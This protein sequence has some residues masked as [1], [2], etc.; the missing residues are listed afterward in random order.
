MD[1]HPGVAPP[2]IMRRFIEWNRYASW[3]LDELLDP[4]GRRGA[5]SSDFQAA[6]ESCL[7]PGL[8]IL[9]VGGGKTPAVTPELKVSLGAQVI[10]IDISQEELSAAPAGSYDRTIC[11][12]IA[13]A[14]SLPEA[15]LAIAHSVTEHVRDPHAMYRN[16][17]AALR[18]G[19]V[20]ISYLPNKLAAH[21]LVNSLLPHRLTRALL[22]TFHWESSDALGFKAYYRY[23]YPSAME[24]LLRQAGFEAMEFRIHYRSQYGNFFVPLHT[25]ELLW[26]LF[27]S[28]CRI[29]NL[30]EGFTVTAR[31]PADSKPPAQG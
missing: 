16:I 2:V 3:R 15:D 6:L 24:R 9:D 1:C 17:F 29:R 13:A 19:G 5:G 22:K 23:C 21:A 14:V 28:R 10:G 18:P 4:R 31:K 20:S 7:R 11:A 27:T 25:C 8:V 12:D 26:Q 30:C